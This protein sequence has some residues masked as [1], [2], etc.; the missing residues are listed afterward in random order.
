M[1]CNAGI[2]ARVRRL[3]PSRDTKAK[4]RKDTKA[5][6]GNSPTKGKARAKASPGSGREVGT[7]RTRLRTGRR[8]DGGLDGS[9]EIS[10]T[11]EGGEVEQVVLDEQNAVEEQNSP[12]AASGKTVA[13]EDS[14]HQPI[15]PEK[16]SQNMVRGQTVVGTP[17]ILA[18][19]ATS[20]ETQRFVI[21]RE[22]R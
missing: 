20:E 9:S 4:E 15:E 22:E 19:S 17:L 16:G 11:G 14:F 3:H 6:Q 2:V 18:S 21:P 10:S 7:A 8:V 12:S 5:S 1:I 13:D